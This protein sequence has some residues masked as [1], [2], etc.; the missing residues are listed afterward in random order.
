MPTALIIL[1]AGQGTRMQSDR[2]K[3]LHAIAGVPML[4]HAIAAGGALAPERRVVV[5]GFGGDAVA[6]AAREF[7]PDVLIAAQD[8]Q[9]GTGHAV[10]AVRDHLGDFSGDALILYGDTPFIRPDT[11]T[12]MAEA[13]AAG[14]DLVVLGFRAADPG[15]YGRLVA[16]GDQ[17]DRIV[18]WQDASDKERAITLCNSGVML[19]DA[20]EMLAWL[21]AVSPS[22][23]SGEIYL[24]DIVEVARAEDRDVRIVTCAE[25]ETQGINTRADLAQAEADF[26]AAARAAALNAG[27]TLTAPET[28]HFA[29]DTMIG[30]DAIIE[31]HVVFGPGASVETGATV[32]AFTHIEGAHVA[33]GAVVGPYARLRPGAEIGTD[34][35]VGNFV[36][37]KNTTLG[38]GTKVD[39]LSYV[40]DASVGPGSKIGAG[41]I[42][43]NY[44]GVMK[45]R[46]EIGAN[47]F[48]G[49]AT[50]LVAPV[51]LGDGA[52]TGSGSVIT[53]DVAAG[54]LA[55]ARARQENK[56]GA[57]AKIFERLRKLKLMRE[58]GTG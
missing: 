33:A 6:H 1:A 56:P 27:V 40:G 24:T 30:R 8:E 39:H 18:E 45:H 46:T 52:M 36:E 54:D 53:R 34:A 20:G 3:V 57:A 43:C 14:A 29:F 55:L 47:V 19:A 38:D 4:V 41:T 9:R 35:R 21:D 22:P 44:D 25:A 58:D 7:D 31:P 5:V 23:A 16:K 50:M 48:V 2:P 26:Q 32:R 42:T 12:T 51:R 49:S 37:I 28:V 17:L 15:R 10:L 11:L 13:R